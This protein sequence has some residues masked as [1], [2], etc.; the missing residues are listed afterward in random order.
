MKKQIEDLTLHAIE[1]T[2]F[3]NI[4]LYICIRYEPET[5]SSTSSTQWNGAK[6]DTSSQDPSQ[7]KFDRSIRI[8][9]P[10]LETQLA[11]ARD[12]FSNIIPKIGGPRAGTIF[13][14]GRSA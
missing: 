9:D 13:P 2:A 3:G 8:W 10:S 6:F 4:A 12:R 5:N 14:F 1:F 11:P 7:R